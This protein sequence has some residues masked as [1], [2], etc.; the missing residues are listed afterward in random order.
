[1]VDNKSTIFKNKKAPINKVLYNK[2]S[3]INPSYF[4]KQFLTYLQ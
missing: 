4:Y 2:K 1:M 3:K